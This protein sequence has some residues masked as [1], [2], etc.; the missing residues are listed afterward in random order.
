MEVACNVKQRWFDFCLVFN[1]H[2]N[3]LLISSFTFT[4]F[5]STFLFFL[6]IFIQ[7]LFFC[8]FK[9][10]RQS[11]RRTVLTYIYF[12]KKRKIEWRR[13]SQRNFSKRPNVPPWWLHQI[14]SHHI[15]KW[16]NTTCRTWS[17]IS[18]T[19]LS[20]SNCLFEFSFFLLINVFMKLSSII[21]KY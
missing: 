4:L 10:K 11:N 16:S 12:F 15:P 6:K 2:H 9:S 18:F 21:K 1:S 17:E 14:L 7:R 13:E 3:G 19:S 20:I 8:P 5:L